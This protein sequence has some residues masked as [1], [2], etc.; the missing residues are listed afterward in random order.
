MR[1]DKESAC[2]DKIKN[3]LFYKDG[4]PI[5]NPFDEC[6]AFTTSDS[7]FAMDYTSYCN[8]D[9]VKNYFG[10]LE[11]ECL[12]FANIIR[13]AKPNPANSEFPDFIFNNGFIEHFQITSSQITRKGATHARKES[14]YLR[15]VAA[16][17]ETIK[18]E[19][20]ETPGFDRVRSKSWGF[21]NPAHSH[22]FLMDSFK[23]NWEHH[24]E[25]YKKYSGKKDIGIFMIEYPEI[26]LA[27]CENVYGDWTDGMAQGDMREQESFKD[28]R[29]SRDKELLKYIYDF[30]S[31][32]KYVVF[33]NPVRCEVIR[34]E[35]I[36]Y[37]IS[38][39]PWD[40][41]IYPMQVSTFDTLLNIEIPVSFTGGDEN[42][43]KT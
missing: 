23:Q 31:V 26:A 28:Y 33:V 35:N 5:C 40:Y 42:N 21:Q 13:I 14:D 17:T 32:I 24:M 38:L 41:C 15:R 11:S 9:F 19:W 18:K 6:S 30:S 8:L 10:L 39:M 20:N 1:G 29:L 27:M 4:M 25:S 37:L 7:S 2:F 16:E 36:P 3:A 22:D 12:E 34:T 43:D